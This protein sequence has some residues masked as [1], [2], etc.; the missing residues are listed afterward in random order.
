MSEEAQPTF[1]QTSVE[2]KTI[3]PDGNYAKMIPWGDDNLLPNQVV[4][5]VGANP[6]MSTNMHFNILNAYG[7]GVMPVKR[8]VQNGKITFLPYEGNKEVRNFF[9]ENRTDVYL[10]EQLNDLN[11]FHNVFPEVI[12]NKENGAKRKIVMLNSKEA[13]FS[14]WSEIEK[15]GTD[16][17]RIKWHYYYADWDKS[18]DFANVVKTRVLDRLSPVRHLR[19]MM[20]EDDKKTYDKRVNRFVVPVS[21]PSP[22]RP[23]YAKPYWFSLFESGIYD[24]SQKIM[25]FKNAM[26]DNQANI[27]YVVELG[28]NYFE[29]I[30]RRE[31]ITDDKTKTARI[32]KEYA[33][34]DKFLKNVKNTHKSII[35]HQKLDPRGSPYPMI[36][37]TP[38][39][40]KVGGELIADHEEVANIMAYGMSVHPSLVGAAP[41]ANKSINGTEAREL[42]ILK[43]AQ[44]K[45][46]RDLLLYP[47]SLIKAIN[48]WPEDLFFTIPNIELT[49]LDNNKSGSQTVIPETT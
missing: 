10:L 22:G 47:F 23:Y 41:G 7:A 29:E 33:D 36:K 35:T 38:I 21:I 40:N 9:E 24:F 13:F 4:E 20:V 37:I 17:G 12:F 46:I 3:D 1:Y 30:Y 15:T 31:K 39:E 42:Y 45:P 25:P 26:L 49:T 19:E 43:Q 6:F 14:R 32:K 48:N 11:Y 2:P 28:P 44:F 5:K 16:K 18:V 27:K 34:I 8:L